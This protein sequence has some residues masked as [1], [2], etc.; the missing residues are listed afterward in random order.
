MPHTDLSG[1]EGLACRDP[2]ANIINDFAK[3]RA[4][5][6]FHQTAVMHGSSESKYFGAFAFVAAKGGEPIGPF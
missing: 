3:F 6:H 2:T 1:F 4:D 5:G